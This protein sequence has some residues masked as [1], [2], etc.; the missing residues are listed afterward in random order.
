MV[1]RWELAADA[2]LVHKLLLQSDQQHARATRTRAPTR[3]EAS[4]ASHVAA[5]YVR[6]QM[7][8]DEILGMFTLS[9]IPTF[10]PSRSVLPDALDPMYLQRLVVVTNP[11]TTADPLVGLRCVRRAIDEAAASGADALRSEAN[12]DLSRSY[13]LLLACGLNPFGQVDER[14]DGLRI[15]RLH[16]DLRS[17]RS[18]I[19][20]VST[21]SLDG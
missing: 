5:G 4:T 9:R 15:V 10:D 20:P 7:S 14:S 2:D 21:P 13:S 16:M 19:S 8:G 1:V 17:C 3:S 12:P 11:V 6:L 18:L